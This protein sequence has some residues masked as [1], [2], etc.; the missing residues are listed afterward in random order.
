MR[1]W[2]LGAALV[3]A[4]LVSSCATLSDPE[5]SPPEPSATVE[6]APSSSPEPSAEPTPEPEPTRPPLAELVVSTEGLGPLGIGDT[7]VEDPVAGM[8]VFDP[9]FCGPEVLGP[10][11][12]AG[13]WTAHPDYVADTPYGG[14]LAFGPAAGE[15]DVVGR[16]DILAP[17]LRTAEGIGIGSTEAELVSA[18]PD[19]VATDFYATRLYAV[20]GSRGDLHLEVAIEDEFAPWAPEDVGS[21]RFLRIVLA[22]QEPYSVA[23]TDNVVPGCL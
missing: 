16:I 9:E 7:L 6:P 1:T 5:T 19:A 3:A 10:G 17:A 21:V 23:F 15:D 20:P 4:L 11:D 8:V 22:G 18:Y 2:G 14:P 13:R 12:E